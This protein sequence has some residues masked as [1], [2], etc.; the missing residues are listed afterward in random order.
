MGRITAGEAAVR[1]AESALLDGKSL[2][3]HLIELAAGALLGLAQRH[4]L[5]P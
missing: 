1:R 2:D 5:V 4:H 3:G